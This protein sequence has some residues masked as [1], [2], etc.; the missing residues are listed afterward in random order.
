MTA[1]WTDNAWQNK[2]ALQKLLAGATLVLAV[3]LVLGVFL[4]TDGVAKKK[5]A[6]VSDQK[7]PRYVDKLPPMHFLAGKPESS[8]SGGW[9][10]NGT[11]LV[12]TDGSMITSEE[13]PESQAVPRDG[14]FMLLM[15][16]WQGGSFVVRH[17]IL[18]T[19]SLTSELGGLS[20]EPIKSINP[21]ADP[22]RTPH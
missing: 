11:P 18:K 5:P 4:V 8:F 20:G 19:T 21:R 12:F 13:D 1:I 9:E 2:G 15:G 14:Q 6:D 22:E 16:H 7:R 3:T 17:A 10:L